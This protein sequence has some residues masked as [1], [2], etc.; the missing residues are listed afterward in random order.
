[1]VGDFFMIPL[2]TPVENTKHTIWPC[3][4]RMIH[5]DEHTGAGV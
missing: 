3:G 5:C 2:I 1:M 4:C